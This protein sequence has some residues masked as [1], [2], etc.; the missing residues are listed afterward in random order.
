[1]FGLGLFA[2]AGELLFDELLFD[3]LLFDELLF[4]ELLFD[5]LLFP[6]SLQDLA[7]VAMLQ[8]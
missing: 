1:M 6:V 4:D 5:E 7:S 3:E 2:A 8:S